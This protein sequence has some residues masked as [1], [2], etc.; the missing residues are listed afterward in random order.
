MMSI[1]MAVEKPMVRAR[2]AQT[3]N[4]TTSLL[5]AQYRSASQHRCWEAEDYW[6]ARPGCIISSGVP[7][8]ARPIHSMQV[9]AFEKNCAGS[10]PSPVIKPTSNRRGIH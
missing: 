3:R 1:R 7:S 2:P 4:R 5:I 9:L 6:K 10:Q 8:L